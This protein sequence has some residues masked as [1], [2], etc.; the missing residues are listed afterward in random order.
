MFFKMEEWQKRDMRRNK[1]I[2]EAVGAGDNIIMEG[3]DGSVEETDYLTAMV[4]QKWV[5][6]AVHPL[7]SQLL[8]KDQ[9]EDFGI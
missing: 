8:R 2:E 1:I 3:S 5:E 6:K 9:N 7:R 4:A